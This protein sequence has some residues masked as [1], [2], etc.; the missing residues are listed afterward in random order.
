M[1][2]N[3]AFALA[4][5]GGFNAHGAGFLAAASK[6]RVVPDL[7][8]ATSG[9]IIV[10]AD[11]LRK[12]D[13]KSGLI[14]PERQDNPFAQL[15][16]AVFGY[17]GVFEPAYWQTI[18]R[19]W[20]PPSLRDSPLTV[21]ADRL[22]PAQQYV[23]SR[24]DNFFEEIVDTFNNRAEID[25]NPIGILFNAY[26]LST[27]KAV[28]YGN[29]QA[30]QMLPKV[31]ALA[32]HQ[33]S[34]DVHYGK[35]GKLETDVKPITVESLKAALWLSLYGFEN[36]PRGELDG[37]YLR[38]CLVSELH[39]F[40]RIFVARPLA[41]GW[42]GRRPRNWFEVQDWQCEMWFS[43]GYKAEVDALNRINDLIDQGHL[44]GTKYR[45]VELIEIEPETPA[46]Y[47]NYF[48]EHELVYDRAFAKADERFKRLA[49]EQNALSPPS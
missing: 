20:T 43:V 34:E 26:D 10:L 25:D 44:K 33:R 42:V 7:V 48:I 13:L 4:G 35:A 9:Q 37:A 5:L 15:N 28:L 40:S 41:N 11:W 19:W 49:E 24:K 45:K 18:S 30:Q 38:S 23:P 46:G 22:L 3:L 17:P 39:E 1:P 32:G 31:S 12:G 6:H 21:L 47:F 29:S 36:L 14:D 16:T 8:T 2:T 27:G